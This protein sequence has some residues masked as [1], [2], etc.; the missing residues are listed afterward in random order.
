M[1]RR[2]RDVVVIGTSAGGLETL[3]ALLGQLVGGLP[4]ALFLVQHLS[5]DSSGEG[6]VTRF[7][8]HAAFH[9]KLAEHG[10][11]FHRG[12]LYIAP[13]DHHLLIKERTLCVTRGARENRHRP[14]ID[15]ALR[16]AAVSHGPRVIGVVL[17]GMLDDGSA[18][19]QAVRRCGGVTVVQ[20][21]KDAEYPDMPANA[22]RAVKVD[23]CL[24]LARMGP[25]LETLTREPAG[26]ARP[27]PRDL[28]VEAEIAEKVLSDISEAESLGTRMPYGCPSCGG[29]L[30]EMRSEGPER[31]RCHTGHAFTA[32]SLL[33][34][35][36]DKIDESLWVTLRQLE[37]RRNL[38]LRMAGEEKHTHNKRYYSDKASETSRHIKR[39][40]KMLLAP[41]VS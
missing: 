37:E 22:L 3:D 20:D 29:P 16:S 18:G 32:G 14:A 26:K 23:H 28:R 17:T 36:A 6:L 9:C 21:P 1:P 40:R 10:E 38:L 33:A 11:R 19:L 15:P 13:P 39:V 7:G 27:V 12:G 35:Q 25:L 30:W 5:P 4:A 24:P 2:H 41:R 8:R 34:A 31:F